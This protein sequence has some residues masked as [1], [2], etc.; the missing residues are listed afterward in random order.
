MNIEYEAT[1][2]N[3][4]KDEIRARL[5]KIGAKLLKPEFLMKRVAFYVPDKERGRWLRVRDEDDKITMSLKII[6][7]KNNIEDQKEICLEIDNFDEGV[8]FLEGVKCGKKAYHESKREIWD[9]DGVEVCIDEWPFLEPFVEIEGK[10][11]EE[12]KKASEKLGFDY[13]QAMFC[14]VAKL[15]NL[16]YGIS[17]EIICNQTNKITFDKNPFAKHLKNK[18]TVI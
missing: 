5:K 4:N 9:L 6:G 7:K 17:E 18:K 11:E 8:S 16:K 14:S 10:N 12:V 3:I 1:F 2:S 13:S 15:Y